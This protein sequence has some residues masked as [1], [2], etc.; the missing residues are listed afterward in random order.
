MENSDTKINEIKFPDETT[1]KNRIISSKIIDNLTEKY[2]APVM[3]IMSM[4]MYMLG[5]G[6]TTGLYILIGVHT[7]LFLM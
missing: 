1:F 4:G 2:G 7:M 6:L 5:I 3:K